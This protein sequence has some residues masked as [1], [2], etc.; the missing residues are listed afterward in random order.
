MREVFAFTGHLSDLEVDVED[1]AEAVLRFENDLTGNLHLDYFRRD[2]RH[3]LEVV[4]SQ[5][6][7]YWDHADSAVRL[8]TPQGRTDFP[9]A[10]RF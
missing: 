6:T 1:T 3:D 9:R 2:K 5:G 10:R 7:L 8:R 4:G